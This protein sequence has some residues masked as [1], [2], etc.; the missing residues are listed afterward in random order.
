MIEHKGYQAGVIEYVP[1]DDSFFGQVAGIRDVVTFAGRSV[2]ELRVA[3]R[4]SVDEYLRFCREE[5]R[6]PNR[7]YESEFT[8]RLPADVRDRLEEL[9]DETGE[10]VEALAVRAIEESVAEPAAA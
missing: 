5:G 2:R 8:L 7:P 3:F 1:E 10:T 9:A 4:D 6:E